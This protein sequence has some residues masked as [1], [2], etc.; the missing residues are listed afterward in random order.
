DGTPLHTFDDFVKTA[1]VKP[2]KNVTDA[3]RS[4]KSVLDAFAT[5]LVKQ[6]QILAIAAEADDEGTN[7]MMSDYIR[8]Q[9][10]LVWMYNAYLSK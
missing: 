10:K 9:E 5:I 4:V 1:D 3:T 7:A 8:E 6:R 2:V